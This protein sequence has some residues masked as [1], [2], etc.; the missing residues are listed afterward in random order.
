[1]TDFTRLFSPRSIAIVGASTDENT[2][3]GQPVRFLREHGYAGAVYP[4][5]PK[6][7]RIGAL[8]CY[9]D[10]ASLPEVPD[11]ALVAVA[12]RRVPETL[13]QLGMPPNREAGQRGVPIR[14]AA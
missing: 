10:V 14:F 7:E 13:R 4:V 2:T 1:M 8:R 11:L 5:N 12:A 3:S 9:P 6:V